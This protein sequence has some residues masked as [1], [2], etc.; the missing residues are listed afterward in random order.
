M[1]A[2]SDQDEIAALRMKIAELRDIIKTQNGL[3][4]G[5]AH[6]VLVA[7]IE[8]LEFVQDLMDSAHKP[9][10]VCECITVRLRS[11]ERIIE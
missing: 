1:A 3:I 2:S 9:S 6:G 8:E 11:L 7:R 5:I 4:D 10:D